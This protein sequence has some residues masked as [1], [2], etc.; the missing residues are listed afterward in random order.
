MNNIVQ[1][2]IER[3]MLFIL[4][5]NVKDYVYIKKLSHKYFKLLV[6]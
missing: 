5:S 2:Q 1:I 6:N 3:F 4:S